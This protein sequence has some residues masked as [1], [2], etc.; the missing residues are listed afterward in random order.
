[1]KFT[2]ECV[3]YTEKHVLVKQIFTNGLKMGLLLRTLGEKQRLSG[4]E[5]ISGAA[6]SKGSHADILLEHER[7]HH[8]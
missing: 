6:V 4:N 3:V 2:K 8:S 5:Q 1:M 7:A